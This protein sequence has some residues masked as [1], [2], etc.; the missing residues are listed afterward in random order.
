MLRPSLGHGA[1]SMVNNRHQRLSGKD[2][3]EVRIGQVLS[4]NAKEYAKGGDFGVLRI[5]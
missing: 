2:T 4:A 3:P 1:E 5:S